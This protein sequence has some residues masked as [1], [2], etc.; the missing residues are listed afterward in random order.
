MCCRFGDLL[1][2]SL[3]LGDAAPRHRDGLR[4]KFYGLL[5]DF[6]AA[7]L[8]FP[9]KENHSAGGE[10]DIV[11]TPT[12]RS[13]RVRRTLR[14]WWKGLIGI[15]LLVTPK[16]DIS[17]PSSFKEAINGTQ[18]KFW[19]KA[20]DKELSS[21]RQ[22]QTWTLVP[23]PTS[24]NV[25]TSRWVLTVKDIPDEHGQLLQKGKGRLVVRGFHNI[26]VFDY[27]ETFAPVIKFTT[28]RVLLAIVAHFNLELHQM[29]VVKAFLNGD[30]EWDIYMGQPEGS[31]DPSKP[32]H[33]CK[34]EKFIY[35]LKQASRQWHKK[36]D[37][38][39]INE[40]GFKTTRSDACFYTK[41][42][43]GGFM[44]IPLYVDHQLLAGSDLNAVAWMKA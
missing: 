34:L 38:F 13:G 32:N 12:R 15:C 6:P 40:L 25:L 39:L 37:D 33:V 44:L 30:L 1:L 10:T 23:R 31:V 26:E 21:Q 19:Q 43:D 28:I 42:S 7:V 5:H 14:Q 9:R 17:I 22:S 27:S 35:G 4:A 2:L 3:R 24:S 8:F 29:D 16:N 18:S 11:N 41:I 36:I 20:V